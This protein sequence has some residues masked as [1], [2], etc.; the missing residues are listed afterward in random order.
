MRSVLRSKDF[1]RIEQL[2]RRHWE[3]GAESY[4]EPLTNALKTPQ[5]SMRLRMVQAA[6]LTEIGLNQGLFAPIG[7][8]HGKTLISLLA[9]HLLDSKRPLLL[10]PAQLRIATVSKYC[11][12]LSKHWQIPE[13]FCDGSGVVSYSTLSTK[14]GKHTLE[15]KQPDLIICDEVH[16]LKSA[17][18][19]RTKRFL[20]YMK[21][22][23]KTRFV[24][25][26]GTV[27]KKSIREYWHLIKLALPDGCP[28]P[29]RW[30]EMSDWANA[31]DENIRPEMRTSPGALRFLCSDNETPRDGYRR[32]LT[33]TPGVIATSESELGTSLVILKKRPET[34][35]KIRKAL[36][37][38][39]CE[40]MTPGGE[41]VSDTLDYYRKSRELS[42]GYYYRWV[43][44]P[45]VSPS[46]KETWLHS[47]SE[48]RRLVL[49]LIHI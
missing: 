3:D 46:Q 2:P 47:R 31:L 45:S 33:Q 36:E 10:V 49:S 12:E 19:A 7:V 28:L 35:S 44:D 16:Y 23:P 5:G 30:P 41:D 27:T 24:G 20:R 29:L 22:N 34:P 11:R 37:Q 42:F 4:V 26:S 14:N 8:G 43:W 6:A 38:L 39:R 40:W 48:W 1:R 13:S 9:P 18:A 21:A 25:M 32:R 15:E 17:K